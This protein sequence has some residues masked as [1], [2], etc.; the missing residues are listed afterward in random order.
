MSGWGSGFAG[1]AQGLKA[2]KR[3]VFYFFRPDAYKNLTWNYTDLGSK[4]EGA[5]WMDLATFQPSTFVEIPLAF[6]SGKDSA[7]TTGPGASCTGLAGGGARG[8]VGGA[9]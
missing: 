7:Q 8:G 9:R 4:K 2:P 3:H 5:V 6:N 1:E